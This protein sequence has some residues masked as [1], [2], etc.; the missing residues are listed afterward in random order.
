MI[1]TGVGNRAVEEVLDEPFAD[2]L[3]IDHQFFRLLVGDIQ[4]FLDGADSV[5]Q[6]RLET[7]MK[8]MGK[9]LG[10]DS[11]TPTDD[12]GV[13]VK[14]D[15]DDIA[16]QDLKGIAMSVHAGNHRGQGI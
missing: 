15:P 1:E 14:S 8:A 7:K 4:P 6:R 12:D 5:L 9:V 11:P 2:F 16:G 3:V 10:E 13:A